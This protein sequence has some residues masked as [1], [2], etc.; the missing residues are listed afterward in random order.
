[1]TSARALPRLVA[2]K[3]RVHTRKHPTTR[4]AG[5]CETRAPSVDRPG[6][7]APLKL[8]DGQRGEAHTVSGVGRPADTRYL[9]VC[10]GCWDTRVRGGGW[11]VRVF[12]FVFVLVL[13]SV[14]RVQ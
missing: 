14:R 6:D 8:P 4:G 10:L 13:V 1:M 3:L 11:C 2:F 7:A 12:V 5:Y 9:R